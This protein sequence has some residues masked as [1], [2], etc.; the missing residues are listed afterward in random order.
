M[1][2]LLL[3]GDGIADRPVR[4][5]GGKTPLESAEMPTLRSIEK[6]SR[7]GRSLTVP[8]N[9][10]PGSDTA[11]LSI[12]GNDPRAYYTGRSPLEA[13]GCG[14]AL[15]PGNISLRL[16]LV[17]L[18]GGGE[19]ETA[20]IVSHNGS[21]IPGEEALV[22]MRDMMA[23]TEV[24]GAMRAL[25]MTIYPLPSFRH[26]GVIG[27]G[28]GSSFA[29]TPPHDIPGKVVAEYLPG[30]GYGERITAFMRVS[31][32]FLSAYP[33]NRKRAEEGKGMANCVWPWG[34]GKL[35]PLPDFKEKYGKEGTVITAVP[36]V[37]G[38][39]LLMGLKAPDIEG[40][41]GELDTNY[42]GKVDAA[43]DA[44]RGGDDFVC[45]HIEAPDEMSHNGSLPDKMQAL[46]DLDGKVLRPLLD[47]LADIGDFRLLIMSD[48]ATP[49]EL[50]IH[51]GEAVPYLIYQSDT[52]LGGGIY[53]EKEAEKG[54]YY[55]EGSAL[56]GDFLGGK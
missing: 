6:K 36:L 9:L 34:D 8:E 49:V 39:A 28:D 38:I 31:Y 35:V 55:A 14:I 33:I 5:L 16:N 42:Q 26:I 41:T 29:F 24:Q 45:V 37:K 46:R 48:H 27:K 4:E 40:A 30:G 18:V 56:M 19:L 11:I 10:P 7:V 17:T 50:R 44:L 52:N 12:F 53:T 21:S 1:K 43:L 2:Y 22:L 54:D 3:I 13:A 23:D 20:T 51:T 47:G 32:R 15:Q 25:D